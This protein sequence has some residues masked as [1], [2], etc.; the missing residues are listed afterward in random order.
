MRVLLVVALL[1]LH[2][3]SVALSASLPEAIAPA[4][5]ATVYLPLWPLSAAGVPVF[6]GAAAGG[7]GSP[8][9]AGWLVLLV[10]WSLLWWSVVATVSRFRRRRAT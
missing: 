10:V 2:A 1:C 4:V 5:A 6:A 8:S 3:A 7:W 9:V